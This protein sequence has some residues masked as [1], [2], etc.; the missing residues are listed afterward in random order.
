M[1]MCQFRLKLEEEPRP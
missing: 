1:Q